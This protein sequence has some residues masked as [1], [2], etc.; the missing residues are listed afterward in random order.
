ALALA[1]RVGQVG[2]AQV[3]EPRFV[4]EE[5]HLRRG[6]GLE[7][8]DDALGARSKVRQAGQAALSSSVLSEAVI[9]QQRREG[10]GAEA[11][12][13]RLDEL[14]ARQRSP[15]FVQEIHVVVH[16]PASFNRTSSR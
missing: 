3:A 13:R 1:N 4:V 15:V 7:Q 10:G 16:F 11:E 12:A 2:A 5:V 9:R 14:P 6:A 8:V